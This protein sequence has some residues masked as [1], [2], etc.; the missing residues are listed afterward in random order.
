[1]SEEKSKGLKFDQDKPRLDLL[2]FE[3]LLE[4]GKVL[5]F[6]AKKYSPGNWKVVEDAQSRYQAALLRHFAAMQKG[7]L[8]DPES[9]LLHS[10]HIATCA[11]FLIHFDLLKLVAGKQPN[12]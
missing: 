5:T 7:D 12:E 11:I 8:L 10:A 6:G 3:C 2:P 9:C 4:V 1:M